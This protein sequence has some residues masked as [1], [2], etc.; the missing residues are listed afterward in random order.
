[1]KKH[2]FDQVEILIADKNKQLRSSLKGVLHQAGFRKII[3]AS[4]LEQMEDAISITCPDLLLCDIGLEG[5]D[6]CEA[7]R[8]LRHS[9][10][11]PN[12]FCSVILFVDVPTPEIVRAASQAGLDDLQVK[13]VVG[14]KVIDRVNYLI[15][16]RK[17]FVVTTD[18]IGPDRRKGAR[19]GSLKVPGVAVPNSVEEKV[20]GT[21]DQVVFKKKV[22][23]TIW[24]V[25]AQKI[26]RH[27]YQIGYLVER[28]VPAYQEGR[29][30][31]E[32]LEQV[33]RLVM[34]SGD[35]S[36]RL[37]ESD[38]THIADLVGTLAKVAHALWRSGT[39]PNMKDLSLLAELSTAISATFK[40]HNVTSSVTGEIT[41]TVG[42]KYKD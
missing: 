15:E 35:I 40:A 16:K 4:D 21:Y 6:V 42:Q 24:E 8:K 23:E 2:R 19:P 1:M 11:G 10:T 18:Y 41:S 14:Q 34:V 36:Q 37:K 38:Y 39:D 29:I 5:G 27:A 9:Q 26:E 30:N 17:P 20:K 33:A 28:I 22:E 25:N 32:S 12:P 7:I 3:E 13:P 31:R